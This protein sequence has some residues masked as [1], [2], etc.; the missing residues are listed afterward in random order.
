MKTIATS[1]KRF[2]P[3]SKPNKLANDKENMA[4]A[5]TKAKWAKVKERKAKA[6]AVAEA[7]VVTN[8]PKGEGAT[9]M[10]AGNLLPGVILLA[11]Q[12][13]C[14]MGT[15]SRAYHQVRGAKTESV[16]RREQ[17]VCE[18]AQMV[19]AHGEGLGETRGQH[20]SGR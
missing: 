4:T 18:E 8:L 2:S 6:K 13:Q 20:G 1:N 17:N 11:G 3:V 12:L 9:P 14:Q 15:P 19:D 10:N 5:K 16:R 7:E